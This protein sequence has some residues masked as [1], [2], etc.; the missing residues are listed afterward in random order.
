MG[1]RYVECSSKEMN[2]VHELFDLAV[3]IAV[4]E[5]EKKPSWGT[6]SEGNSNGNSNNGEKR[7]RKRNQCLIL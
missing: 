4:D 3:T 1:A 2:G 5:G 6:T 7:R